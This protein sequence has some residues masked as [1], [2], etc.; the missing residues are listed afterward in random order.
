MKTATM[1]RIVLAM[2]VAGA[3]VAGLVVLPVDDYLAE[4]MRRIESAGAWGPLLLAVVYAVACVLLVPGSILTLGAGFLFGLVWGTVAVSVGSV[5]G[6]TAAFLVGRTFLRGWVELQMADYP[7]FQ[8]IDRAVGEQG[9][10]IVLLVRLSPIFP[11]NLL[12]YAFGLTRVRLWQYIVASWI[13]MFPATVVYVYSGSVLKSLTEVAA[14]SA[15]RGTSQTAY[16]IAGLI[17]TVLA[18]VVIARVAGR[19]LDDAVGES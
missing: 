10:K 13:G 12:N 6:A 7:R 14:G 18:T 11:F 19:A 1:P 8:A 2:A 9:F 3:I 16:L 4:L 17:A 15:D 5:V